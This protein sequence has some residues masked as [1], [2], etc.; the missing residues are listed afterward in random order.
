MAKR[1]SIR[2]RGADIFLVEEPTTL[3]QTPVSVEPPPQSAEERT[4]IP[5]S[6]P[7]EVP[8]VKR[9]TRGQAKKQRRSKDETVKLTVYIQPDLHTRLD[10]LWLQRRMQDV[11]AQKSLLVEEALRLL[12]ERET[13]SK[14][15][16]V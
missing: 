11:N 6:P 13:A 1:D 4:D 2:G 10:Q 3:P 7:Q 16:D 12:F 8:T 9:S 5:A 15:Q 14:R